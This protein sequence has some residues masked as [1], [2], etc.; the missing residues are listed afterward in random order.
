MAHEFFKMLKQDHDKVK[1]ILKE[2]EDKTDREL[3]S[4][5]ELFTRLKQELIPHMEAEEKIFY[6]T[7]RNVQGPKKDILESIEEHHVG[8]M[9]LDEL[10][11]LSRNAPN[12]LAKLIVFKEIVEHHIEE[13]ED[14]IFDMAEDAIEDD[15]MS[16]IMRRFQEE[17]EKA[18]VRVI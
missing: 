8:R 16:N 12:W 9:V 10:N 5:E 1:K 15:Q 3:A 14:K 4:R 18:M 6:P 17:K 2:L 13:E 7:L 11:G